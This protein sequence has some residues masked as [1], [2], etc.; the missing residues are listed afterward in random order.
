MKRRTSSTDGLG[1]AGPGSKP[2]SAWAP[3][4]PAMQNGPV[5]FGSQVPGA[6]DGAGAGAG[7]S[8][9]GALASRATAGA[10]AVL[11]Q[12]PET[13]TH[14]RAPAP[15]PDSVTHVKPVGQAAFAQSSPQ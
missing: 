14:W 12:L 3:P 8:A 11:L 7:A 10:G 6:G 13:G 9:G 5:N 2:I 15:L 1:D 4:G